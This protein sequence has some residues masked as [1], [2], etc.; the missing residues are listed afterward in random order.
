MPNMN[1]IKIKTNNAVFETTLET[2]K[3]NKKLLLKLNSNVIDLQ[4]YNKN[5]ITTLL[6]YLRGYYDYNH[7][8]EYNL[9]LL[10][11]FENFDIYNI[12]DNSDNNIENVKNLKIIEV[13]KLNIG[14][15]K[16][17]YKYDLL[18][19]NFD[20]FDRFISWNK[21]NCVIKFLVHKFF[22]IKLYDYSEI[23]ID[24]SNYYFTIICKYIHIFNANQRM[25][26]DKFI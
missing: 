15:F 23:L 19:A 13:I 26:S 5:M 6:D 25:L 22:I 11:E 2:I 24:R 3:Q 20:Y 10:I 18:K 16:R 4:E 8:I 9:S 14:G 17:S 7:M 21:N 12:H 1:V